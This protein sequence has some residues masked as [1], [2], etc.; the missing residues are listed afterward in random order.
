MSE[1]WSMA[2][3]GMQPTF[4]QVPYQR[5][6]SPLWVLATRQRTPSVSFFSTQAVFIPICAALI[7]AM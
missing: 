1:F 2:L 4:K 5:S 6:I 3:D 7:A